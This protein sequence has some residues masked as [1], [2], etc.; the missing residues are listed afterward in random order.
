MWKKVL[1]ASAV[2]GLLAGAAITIQPTPAE[3]S[4]AQCREVAR[5][6][7]PA[8]WKARRDFKRYCIREWKAYRAAQRGA[9]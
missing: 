5:A 9:Y 4:R 2:T 6:K 8:D 7:F 3:A 1:I